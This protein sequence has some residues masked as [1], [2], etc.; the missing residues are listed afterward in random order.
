M[1]F[2]TANIHSDHVDEKVLQTKDLA[3]KQDCQVMFDLW[4]IQLPG[5]Q[6][7]ATRV[8]TCN[9]YESRDLYKERVDHIA[10]KPCVQPAVMLHPGNMQL[11]LEWAFRAELTMPHSQIHNSIRER[12]HAHHLQHSQVEVLAAL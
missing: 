8:V 3:D 7:I 9:V 1:N 5:L 6:P 10:T 11:H 4:N 12:I 2:M